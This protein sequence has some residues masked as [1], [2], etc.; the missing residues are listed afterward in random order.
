MKNPKVCIYTAIYGG[1][2][3]LKSQPEQSV[4][5]DLICFSDRAISE[6]NGWKIILNDDRKSMHPRMRAKFFKLMPHKLFRPSWLNINSFFKDRLPFYDYTIW[7]DGSVQIRSSSFVEELLQ[8]IGYYGMAMFIHPDRNCIYEEVLY[9]RKMLK[10]QYLPLDNQV[11]YYRSK[12]YP[13]YSGLMAAGIIVRDMR[14]KKL[15]T[16]DNKWWQEN[17]RWSYQD[18]ISLPFVL[19]KNRYGYDKINLNLWNNH[20]FDLI[21]HHSDE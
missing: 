9:C 1:Y 4:D 7:V 16:I 6:N 21:S 18:Q 12:G 15:K 5:C 10:Y 8:S 11:S 2:D 14:R 3:D 19:W 20:L 13:E 17:L